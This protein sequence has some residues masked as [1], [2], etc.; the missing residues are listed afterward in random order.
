ME[1]ESA[2]SS[3]RGIW[4]KALGWFAVG[5]VGLLAC[6]KGKSG[7][8]AEPVASAPARTADASATPAPRFDEAS[9]SLEMR[10]V[11]AYTKSAAAKVEVQ[12]EAKAPYHVNE[13]YP[14]KLE[15]APTEGVKFDAETLGRDQ[16]ALQ[17][18][19]AVM[20]VGFTPETAGAKTIAGK[21]K[22]SVCTQER[23]LMETRELAL[24]VDVE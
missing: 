2:L 12:L 1:S 17:H 8:E 7:A 10:K 22:F 14:I 23:C 18:Q 11:G 16:V 15:L 6:N 19:R 4:V 20:T 3:G 24:S 21:L 9:F 13:K 5:A